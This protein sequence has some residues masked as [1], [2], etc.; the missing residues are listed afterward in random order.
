MVKIMNDNKVIEY[1][2]PLAL[3]ECEYFYTEYQDGLSLVE[4]IALCHLNDWEYPDWVK[5]VLGKAMLKLYQGTFPDAEM[6]EHKSIRTIKNTFDYR[7][8]SYASQRY[9]KAQK[10]VLKD[11]RLTIDRD[12]VIEAHKR[13]KRDQM[14]SELIAEYSDYIHAIPKFKNDYAVMKAL[15]DV[16][17]VDFESWE[18][19]SASGQ[20]FPDTIN[21]KKLRA[22]DVA[23]GMSEYVL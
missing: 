1:K 19:L 11:L 18:K 5:D 17:A 13:T 8:S 7:D 6:S 4:A 16:L 3:A 15:A 12:S 20:Y 2:D 9:R 21:G 14:L 23:P 10:R 22:K